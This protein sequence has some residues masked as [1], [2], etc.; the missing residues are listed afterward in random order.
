VSNSLAIASATATLRSVL[1]LGVTADA[2]LNDTIVTILPL[3]K[4][5]GAV[6]SNQLNI[7]LYQVQRSAAWSNAQLPWQGKPGESGNPPLA[8]TLYY[9]LTAFGRDNDASQPFGHELIGRAMSVLHDHPV[10]SAEDIKAASAA[11]PTSD[12]DRQPERIRVA[13]HPIT[14]DELS[15]LWTGFASQFRLSAAYEVGVVLIESTR[16]V[17]APLPVLTRGPEDAGIGS[18]PDLM[19]RLPQLRSVTPPANQDAALPLDKVRL[20]GANLAGSGLAVRFDHPLW[21]AP[22]ERPVEPGATATELAVTIPDD[23][24]AWPPGLYTVAVLLQ[25]EGDTTRRATKSL[26]LGLAPRITV[27]PPV[28]SPTELTVSISATPH[29]WPEQRATLLLAEAEILAAPRSAKSD[30]LVFRA[31]PLPA[32]QYRVRL[33]VDGV[34]TILVDRTGEVPRFDPTQRLDVP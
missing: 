11:L 2:E 31:P 4:A 25:P 34:D 24:D 22:V 9:L 3:D 14:L 26:A 23:P 17:R 18:Q 16:A 27:S 30:P 6:T 33:R 12:L 20:S 15:K 21:D 5:R 13:P 28:Q 7:F 10:L 1:E 19:S 8:L 29:V 32:G